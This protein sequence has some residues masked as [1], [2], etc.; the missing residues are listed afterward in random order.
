MKILKKSMPI[1]TALLLF[2][3]CS[4]EPVQSPAP[5]GP[6]PGDETVTF[7]FAVS[8]LV[9]TVSAPAAGLDDTKEKAINNLWV[10][11]YSGD[12]NTLLT[13][14]YYDAVTDLTSGYWTVNVAVQK[15][16][17]SK[18]FFVANVGPDYF[19]TTKPAATASAFETSTFDFSN[20]GSTEATANG[21]PMYG[22]YTG[23]T[24]S[25][26]S[27]P[28]ALHRMVARVQ[29]ICNVNLD[30]KETNTS[31]GKRPADNFKV[32]RVQIM[33]AA[34][35][36]QYQAHTNTTSTI[37][38]ANASNADLADNYHH[39]DAETVS[40]SISKVWY[41][42]E[43]LK[44]QVSSITEDSQ[45]AKANAP[46]GS[47]YIV[48]GGDYETSVLDQET[49][50]WAPV[51]KDTSYSIYLGQDATKDFNVVRNY[52]YKI[53]VTIKGMDTTD[54]RVEVEKGVP[55]GEYVDGE[56]ENSAEE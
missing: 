30:S 10:F 14:E 38:P 37:Y 19:V 2:I 4:K 18:L 52:S 32:T 42:P 25:A 11:Q 16:P 39:Y 24:E 31:N 29:L 48:I 1:L 46:Q 9:S 43:N 28:I 23:S 17:S 6:E 22:T 13:S 54:L 56:W 5:D 55:A 8:T 21:L 47:T 27:D 36:V 3:G 34:T 7:D 40:G 51:L 41:L 15:L 53:T 12:G 50:E 20:W 45:K 33:D 26:P 44:G 49:G 35:K